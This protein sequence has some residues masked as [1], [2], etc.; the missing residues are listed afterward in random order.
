MRRSP[1][2]REERQ[3]YVT[4]M[5]KIARNTPH[6]VAKYVKEKKH[7]NGT[8]TASVDY[9]AMEADVV[10]RALRFNEMN[11]RRN[12]NSRTTTSAPA[13]SINIV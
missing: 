12:G 8:V 4:V 6:L 5:K 11:R 10:R 9:L 7:S 13:A 2:T 1:R 3:R